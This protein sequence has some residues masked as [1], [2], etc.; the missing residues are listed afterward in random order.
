MKSTDKEYL[1]AKTAILAGTIILSSGGE[2]MRAED[3]A[4]RI[5]IAGGATE[6]EVTAYS[7]SISISFIDY[8]GEVFSITKRINRRT[9]H[10]NKITEAN[11]ISRAFCS[12]KIDVHEAY[13]LL[14]SVGTSASYST[15]LVH[16]CTLLTPATF[17]I[18]L[19]GSF[20]D[21]IFAGALGIF[22]VLGDVFNRRTPIH[23]AI[24]NFGLGLVIAL[25]GY[26]LSIIPSIEINLD[27]L[28]PGTIMAL[29]PGV[30]ITNGVHDMLNA[31]YMSGGARFIEAIVT[32]ATL[33]VG[34]GF[35]LGI[36]A[37]LTGGVL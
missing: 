20:F 3:T 33:A 17:T 37:A 21:C 1:L 25:S 7:T 15:A 12:G 9:I 18:L 35:G 6:P 2:T 28:L 29:L 8:S 26:L 24:Y 4:T 5:L 19:G 31:D 11:E 22:L 14:C 16:L 27:T 34:V 32:A 10:L 36:G 13:S 23:P 30:T